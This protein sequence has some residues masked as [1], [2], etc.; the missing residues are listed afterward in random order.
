MKRYLLDDM[1]G[2]WFVGCFEPTCYRTSEFEVALKKYRRGDTEPEHVHRIATELTLIASGRVRM[3]GIE[4]KD[5]EIALLEP[6][7]ATD[8]H[9]LEDT[10]TVVVKL[11]SLPNDKY[12]TETSNTESA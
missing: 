11:P 5:G 1:K 4:L 3:A 9:A 8:F 6:G 10:V 7:E 2:G 12:L